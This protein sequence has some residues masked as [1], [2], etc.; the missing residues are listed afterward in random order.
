MSRKRRGKISKVKKEKRERENQVKIIEDIYQN[1]LKNL[2]ILQKKQ[3][4]ILEDFVKT[5]EQK[6]LEEIRKKLK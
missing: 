5:L 2:R 1:Y 4:K 3:D 6:K